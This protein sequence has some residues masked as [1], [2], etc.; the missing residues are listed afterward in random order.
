MFGMISLGV[1]GLVVDLILTYIIKNKKILNV[2]GFLIAIGFSI[3][4]IIEFK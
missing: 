4:L 1:I 3:V 2:I